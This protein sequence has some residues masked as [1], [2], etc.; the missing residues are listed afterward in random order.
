MLSE[1]PGNR[2]LKCAGSTYRQ[3]HPEQI[4][5]IF[6]DPRT[7]TDIVGG[8]LIKS[9]LRYLMAQVYKG[10]VKP[11]IGSISPGN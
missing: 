5:C 3:D 2:D 1:E 6:A 11:R 8:V 10:A 7:V 9:N 4:W